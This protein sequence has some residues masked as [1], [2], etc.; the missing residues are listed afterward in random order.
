MKNRVAIITGG[1]RGIG[2]AFA[3]ALAEAGATAIIAEI[4]EERGANVEA[5]ITAAGGRA[6]FVATDVTQAASV[7]AM[8]AGALSEF[9]RIDILINCAVLLETLKRGP[10][11]DLPAEEFEAAFKVNVLGTF[12]A[13]QAAVPAMKEAGWGRIINMSS[14]T[15]LTGNPGYVHYVATKSAVIGLTRALARE[16]GGNGITVNAI[17]PGLTE[18]EVDRG[19]E[20]RASADKVIAQQCIPRQEIPDDLVGA[21]MFL[22]SD[23][24]RFVTG[25]SLAV[26][27][28]RTFS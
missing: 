25:Q 12:L 24:S 22:A 21:M 6:R 15:A 10:F 2:R 14:D 16:L 7:A 23:Q 28:G 19:P 17:L 26:N 11:E 9:G 3:K 1:G 27:G 8:A 13:A 5:E 20:R 4:D 18:T